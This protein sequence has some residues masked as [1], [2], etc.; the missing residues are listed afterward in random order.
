MVWIPPQE[1][2]HADQS[3]V[4]PLCLRRVSRAFSCRLQ[5]E[6]NASALTGTEKSGRSRPI[7]SLLLGQVAEETGLRSN[8]L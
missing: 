3:K 2:R 4:I 6:A 8:L 1:A 7:R 5:K